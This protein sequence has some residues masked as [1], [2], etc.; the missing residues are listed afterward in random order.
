MKMEFQT[1]RNWPFSIAFIF[2]QGYKT[3]Q[4]TRDVYIVCGD[5]TFTEGSGIV[6]MFIFQGKIPPN[7]PSDS[8]S[9]YSL[10]IRSLER[11]RSQGS[12]PIH[13]RTGPVDKMLSWQRRL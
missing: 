10:Q 5:S 13:Q 1:E 4:A 8:Q 2:N 9:T 7:R 11:A 3:S 12:A 6:K